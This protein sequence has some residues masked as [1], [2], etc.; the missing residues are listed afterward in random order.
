MPILCFRASGA[1]SSEERGGGGG[2][3]GRKEKETLRRLKGVARVP[4]FAVIKY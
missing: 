1:L 4:V 2:E 3:E